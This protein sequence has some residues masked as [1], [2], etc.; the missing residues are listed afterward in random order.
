MGGLLF[1]GQRIL[2]TRAAEQLPALVAMV[3]ARGGQGVAFPCLKISDDVAAI[4]RGLNELPAV[5]DVLFTSVHGVRAVAAVCDEIGAEDG[6]DLAALLRGKRVAAVGRKTAAALTRLG[7]DVELVPE[8]ASQDGLLAAYAAQGWPERL[9]FFRAAEGRDT[10]I[11]AL[12]ARQ[13]DVQ[14]VRAYRTACPDDDASEVIEQLAADMIDAV[15]L[16]SPKAARCYLQRVG[17]LALANR[18]VVAVISEKM[19]AEVRDLGLKVQVIAKTA[20]F[21]QMLDDLA[22]FICKEKL[23]VFT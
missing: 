13:I 21:E 1:T 2:L 8:L 12:R 18:P 10:V 22:M 23:N 20:S 3:E 9:L 5:S 7:V 16:G 14:L 4:Q 19:A 17:S 6:S 15:L 11:E